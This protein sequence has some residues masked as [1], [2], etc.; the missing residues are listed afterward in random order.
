MLS[1]LSI[2]YISFFE[3]NIMTSEFSSQ[4]PERTEYYNNNRFHSTSVSLQI[5]TKRGIKFKKNK[6][7]KCAHCTHT[8]RFNFSCYICVIVKP[9]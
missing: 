4:T 8:T 5:G 9:K 3:T 6:Q 7:Q 2:F 1:Y